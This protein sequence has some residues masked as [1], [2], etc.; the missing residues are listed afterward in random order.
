M[1]ISL[2]KFQPRT[3]AGLGQTDKLNL[4]LCSLKNH[5]KKI[6]RKY[7]N[8]QLQLNRTNKPCT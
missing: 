2:A 6:M 3:G 4:H 7:N 5:M 8:H 1:Q